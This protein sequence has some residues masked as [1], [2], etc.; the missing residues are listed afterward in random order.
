M[1]PNSSD[2]KAI[3]QEIAN[4]GGY[5]ITIH[6]NGVITSMFGES[7]HNTWVIQDGELKCIS[8]KTI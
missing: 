7:T 6:P 5:A 2:I 4:T 3:F 8:C 1:L